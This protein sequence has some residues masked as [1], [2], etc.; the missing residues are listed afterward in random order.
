ME[1]KKR[2]KSSH[3]SAM[4]ELHALTQEKESFIC[5]SNKYPSKFYYVLN[6]QE[7][8]ANK[9]NMVPLLVELAIL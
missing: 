4:I 9:T 8:I 3:H 7:T 2:N 1:R 6:I 5:L